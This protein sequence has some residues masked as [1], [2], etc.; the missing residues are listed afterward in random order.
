MMLRRYR[1][2]ISHHQEYLFFAHA[3]RV[4]WHRVCVKCEGPTR[5]GVIIRVG[6]VLIAGMMEDTYMETCPYNDEF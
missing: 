2:Y 5:P 6:V 4:S 1:Y 3:C